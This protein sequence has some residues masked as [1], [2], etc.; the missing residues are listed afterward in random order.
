[1]SLT[2]LFVGAPQS[3]YA[4][5]AILAAVVVVSFA[6][7]FGKDPIPFTQK[8][9]FVLLL[10]LI[11]LPGILMTLFQMTCLVTGAGFRNQRWWCAGYAWIVTILLIVY[12]VLL[13]AVAVISL[14]TGEKVLTEIA[15]ADAETFENKMKDANKEAKQYFV[16]NTATE[17]PAVPAEEDVA[18]PP[19]E[20]P[21]VPTAE[22]PPPPAE[23]AAGFRVQGGASAPASLDA[24]EGFDESE[25]E[26]FTSCS[27]PY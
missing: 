5:L 20:P 10:F 19:T 3:K 27:S 1:M 21:A 16:G 24:P 11:S 25:V 8:M 9:A 17:P 18:S 4:A 23:E 6:L 12:C 26:M 22:V 7:L 14:T 15:L 2:R 13:I